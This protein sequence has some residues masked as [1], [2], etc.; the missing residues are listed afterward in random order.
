ME[1]KACYE[2]NQ[3]FG[4]DGCSVSDAVCLQQKGDGTCDGAI[5]GER[6]YHSHEDPKHR[7]GSE[8]EGAADSR[9]RFAKGECRGRKGENSGAGFDGESGGPGAESQGRIGA[10]EGEGRDPASESH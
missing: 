5:P 7:G 1:Y 10:T 4:F 3:D 2:T 6:E 9:R 8:R